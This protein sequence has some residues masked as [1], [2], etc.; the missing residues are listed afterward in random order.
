MQVALRLRG[1]RYKNSGFKPTNGGTC[2][3]SPRIAWE[4][5]RF[6]EAK[7]RHRCIHSAHPIA[8]M[9]SPQAAQRS[10]WNS[11]ASLATSR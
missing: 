6:S 5:G 10:M 1:R 9:L 4:L 8:P 11:G 2:C 3:H 7:P